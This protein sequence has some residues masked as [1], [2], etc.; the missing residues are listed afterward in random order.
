LLGYTGL[1]ETR[2]L[3]RA[4]TLDLLG[5]I[6]LTTSAPRGRAR[7]AAPDCRT[8]VRRGALELLM[9]KDITGGDAAAR[10]GWRR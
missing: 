9:A 8:A 2:P 10:S 7:G 5:Q 4:I 1:I 3:Y 6:A